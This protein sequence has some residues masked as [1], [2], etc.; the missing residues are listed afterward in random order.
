MSEIIFLTD[1]F[2]KIKKTAAQGWAACPR[3]SRDVIS[4]DARNK[5]AVKSTFFWY[6]SFCFGKEKY[7]YNKKIHK[8]HNINRKNLMI[9]EIGGRRYV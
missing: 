5:H 2:L 6:F 9:C 7:I 3:K 4:A 1:L 8:L